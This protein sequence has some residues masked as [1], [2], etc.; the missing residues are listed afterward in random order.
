MSERRI[1]DFT[2]TGEAEQWQVINDTVMGGISRSGLELTGSSTAIFRGEV[3][4]E[5]NGGFASVRT[6]ARD[7]H[8]EGLSGLVLRVR[9]DGKTYRLRLRTDDSYE[10][11]AYQSQFRTEAGQWMTVDLPFSDFVPVFRGSVVRDAPPLDI[12][13]VRRMGLMIADR[14]EGPFRLE[15]E[16]IEGLRK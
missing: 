2:R 5:N 9:G 7:F 12:S 4:F 13:R 15:L 14:Q 11:V 8:L 10:G 16:Y 3:S 6:I 1:I